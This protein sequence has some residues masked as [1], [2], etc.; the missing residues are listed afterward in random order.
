MPKVEAHNLKNKQGVQ[1]WF[2]CPGCKNAH[3]FT[4]PPWSFNGDVENPTFHPSLLCNQHHPQS[5]CHSVV[6]DGKIHF[7]PDCHHELAG[8][9]V[10]MGEAKLWEDEG[11][12]EEDDA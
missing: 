3:A 12:S 6:T 2:W 10:E 7:C 1:Y 8:K 9:T 5:R 11:K 4:V